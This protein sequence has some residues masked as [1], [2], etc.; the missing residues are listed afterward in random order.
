MP[1]S[2]HRNRFLTSHERA[3]HV[4]CVTSLFEKSGLRGRFPGRRDVGRFQIG[5]GQRSGRYIPVSIRLPSRYPN[6]TC[7]A[8]GP[9]G[10]Q[11]KPRATPSSA[12]IPPEQRR[13]SGHGE[14]DRRGARC[15]RFWP[16]SG[17]ALP[18]QSDRGWSKLAEE[19]QSREAA[20]QRR[21]GTA[22]QKSSG[23]HSGSQTA[24]SESIGGRLSNWFCNFF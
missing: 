14:G 18:L 1:V 16:P 17:T 5:L 23:A 2:C 20:E 13:L 8:N 4:L 10:R 12:S 22:N 19:Q 3:L 6:L 21:S 7:P 24:P 9:A 11:P 15:T